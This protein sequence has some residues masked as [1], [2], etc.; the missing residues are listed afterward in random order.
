[1]ETYR[2]RTYPPANRRIQRI[3]GAPVSSGEKKP[4][5]SGAEKSRSEDRSIFT[6]RLIPV[7]AQGVGVRD[8]HVAAPVWAGSPVP[9][10]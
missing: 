6:R 5:R 1:M 8:A 4:R 10:P 3:P 2:G 9:F 7:P